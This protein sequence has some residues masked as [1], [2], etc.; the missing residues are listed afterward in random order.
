MHVFAN[1]M[2]GRTRE[3]KANLSKTIVRDLALMFPLLLHIVT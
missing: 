2:E 1:I 3:E